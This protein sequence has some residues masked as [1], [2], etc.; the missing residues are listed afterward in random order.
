MKVLEISLSFYQNKKTRRKRSVLGF[1]PL[2][3]SAPISRRQ[4]LMNAKRVENSHHFQ[5]FS[6]ASRI[7]ILIRNP[8]NRSSKAEHSMHSA[9]AEC[10]LETPRKRSSIIANNQKV[11]HS[12]I[13]C[14]E[15]SVP[16]E[17]RF[18]NSL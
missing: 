5:I 1:L 16:V 9:S 11:R 12:K 18:Q 4:S 17:A 6:A 7:K 13:H 3:T 14:S 2:K 8:L 10:F 15:H